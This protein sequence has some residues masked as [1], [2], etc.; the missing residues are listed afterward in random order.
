MHGRA[1]SSPSPRLARAQRTLDRDRRRA[2]A[3][4]A[5]IARNA[6]GS[7]DRCA[8]WEPARDALR[9]LLEPHLVGKPSIAVVGAGNADDL[10]LA[11]IAERAREVVLVDLDMPA[12]RA[13]LRRLPRPLRRR[14][15]VVEHDITVGACDQIAAAAGS[16]RLPHAPFVPETP[17]PGAPYDLVIGDLFYSQLLYPALLDLA[18]P[19]PRRKAFEARYAAMLARGAVARLHV[20]APYGRVVHIHDPLAWLPGR[21]QP[22][23]LPEIL[24]A[25]QH[26]VDA[27][28]RLAACG[29]GP[30]ESDPR[31]ALQSLGIPIRTTALWHWPFA[32]GVDYLAC[33]TVAGAP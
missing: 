27:A 7:G 3:T 24:D 12:G 19:G 31:P 26:D 23:A 25:A 28:L 20:S 13:A 18:V 8:R 6:R 10:P 14:I 5:N 29:D 2:P 33:A 21:P 30:V 4:T 11:Q 1:A 16:G 17:L 9:R 22:V 15:K 32:P